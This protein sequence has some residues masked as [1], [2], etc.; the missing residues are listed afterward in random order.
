MLGHCVVFLGKTLYSDSSS[1]HPG[2]QMGTFSGKLDEMLGGGGQLRNGLA[3][4][5]EGSN[6]TPSHL[7]LRNWDKL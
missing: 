3:S 1:L 5:E 7:M 4:Y 6:D 2:I